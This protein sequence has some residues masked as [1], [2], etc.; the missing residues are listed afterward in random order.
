MYT[1][2]VRTATQDDRTEEEF[3]FASSAEAYEKLASLIADPMAFPLHCTKTFI[4][5]P[6]KGSLPVDAQI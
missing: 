5:A 4:V 6:M 2:T 1:L 3:Y